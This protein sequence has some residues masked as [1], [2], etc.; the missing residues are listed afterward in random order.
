MQVIN[1]KCSRQFHL[2]PVDFR[3]NIVWWYNIMRLWLPQQDANNNEK[4]NTHTKI[5]KNCAVLVYIYIL[6][7]RTVINASE[8]LMPLTDLVLI[9][10]FVFHYYLVFI[11]NTSSSYKLLLEL[12][13]SWKWFTL[14][15]LLLLFLHSLRLHVFFSFPSK[16]HC[17][18]Y[19]NILS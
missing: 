12:T 2:R 19:V 6:T 14:F 18:Y 5:T 3:H 17:S 15:R 9:F 8:N 4:K 7:P 11:P 16:I 1:A 10:A 13:V